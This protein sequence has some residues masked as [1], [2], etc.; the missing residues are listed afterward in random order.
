MSASTGNV[1][2]PINIPTPAYT[3]QSHA[4]N[5]VS[6]SQFRALPTIFAIST[7]IIPPLNVPATSVRQPTHPYLA[8]FDPPGDELSPG[9]STPQG[10]GLQ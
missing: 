7:P 5:P 8:T 1:T 10:D 9:I 2:A 6:G 3:C 4:G